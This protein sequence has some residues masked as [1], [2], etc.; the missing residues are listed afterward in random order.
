MV[1][2][3][4]AAIASQSALSAESGEAESGEADCVVASAVLSALDGESSFFA[5]QPAKAVAV[6]KPAINNA[7]I[8]FI[9]F[10]SKNKYCAHYAAL[11][12]I[13]Q[14]FSKVKC[15][16]AKPLIFLLFC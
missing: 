6:I 8:F 1:I 2:S 5:P 4:L 13:Q 14:R 9:C 16:F 15:Y 12:I 10:S 3:P 7:K 11:I